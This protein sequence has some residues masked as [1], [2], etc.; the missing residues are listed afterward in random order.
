MIS[1]V[2]YTSIAWGLFS[3]ALHK[4]KGNQSIS[5]YYIHTD[6]KHTTGVFFTIILLI[7][8]NLKTET[9]NWSQI[10]NNLNSIPKKFKPEK[11]KNQ[12]WTWL[13]HRT[14]NSDIWFLKPLK[15]VTKNM[16]LW[17]YFLKH[18]NLTETLNIEHNN[19][20]FS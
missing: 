13:K 11:L 9:F 20:K 12:T 8:R 5:K 19:G 10:P 7:N 3:A 14:W 16:K 17:T 6:T 15:P 4:S 2:N 18:D 1:C